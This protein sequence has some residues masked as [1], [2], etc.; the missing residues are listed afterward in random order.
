MILALMNAI[1]AIAYIGQE[2]NFIWM[3]SR[4]SAGAL[5]GDTVNSNEQL[6]QIKSNSGF[7]GEGKPKYLEKT[8][9]CREVNQ[10]TQP[11]YHARIEPGPH[12]WGRRVLSPLRHPCTPRSLRNAGRQLV[13][14]RDL[15]KPVRRATNWAKKPLQTFIT[16]S[17]S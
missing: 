2:R 1:Y 16:F 3:S 9:R 15:I 5:I 10:Q 14:I 6:T 11:T 17:S 8:S 13:W 12:W 4:F 7:W